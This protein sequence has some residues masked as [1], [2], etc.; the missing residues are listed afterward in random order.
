M[1]AGDV[2]EGVLAAVKL[3][4]LDSVDGA[5]AYEGGEDLNKPGLGHRRRTRLELPD[6]QGGEHVLYMKRYGPQS[7]G[8]AMRRWL[9][10]GKR[11]SPARVEFE[12]IRRARQAGVATMREVACDEDR[13]LLAS[14][15]SYV[16]VTS[17]PGEAL[18]RCFDTYLGDRDEA[19]VAELTSRLARMVRS[20]HGAGYVHRDFY[21]SHVFLDES[22][23]SGEL[24]LI[25]LARMFRPRF[26][27]LR[28]FIKDLAQLKYSMPAAWTLQY[29]PALLAEYLDGVSPGDRRM[30]EG[31]IDRK[32]ESMRRRDQRRS[33]RDEE[34]K[35]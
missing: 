20:L 30:W 4:G 34:G 33:R 6:G 23:G 24:Y 32:V 9:T 19:A 16:I 27:K 35:T 31:L 18:E 7:V 26:R 28:W 17:V 5:F 14:L 1:I 29:W 10:H 2:P 3:A 15:R 21:A 12:N 8:E 13:C 11:Q 22:A 25:D